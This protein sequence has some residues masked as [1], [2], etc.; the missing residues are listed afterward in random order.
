MRLREALED[1]INII[2]IKV[3]EELGPAKVVH[4]ARKMGLTSLVTSGPI[5]MIS[6]SP[7][8]PWAVSS[9]PRWN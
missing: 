4:Y 1:S 5:N 6:T 9:R 8:W 2:A 7:L 3:V